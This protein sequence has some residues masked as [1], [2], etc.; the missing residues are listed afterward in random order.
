MLMSKTL[1][2]M[3]IGLRILLQII[4]EKLLPFMMINYYLSV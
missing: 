4:D 1:P 3:N 2:L